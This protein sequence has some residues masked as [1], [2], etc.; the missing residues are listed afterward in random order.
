MNYELNIWFRMTC[1]GLDNIKDIPTLGMIED[2]LEKT[3]NIE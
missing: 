1:L 2:S 3:K